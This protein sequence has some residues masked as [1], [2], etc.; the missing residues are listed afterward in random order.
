MSTQFNKLVG[1]PLILPARSV[2]LV[3]NA[4]AG[5]CSLLE[6]YIAGTAVEFGI[7]M[8]RSAL[9]VL[10]PYHADNQRNGGG[11]SVFNIRIGKLIRRLQMYLAAT[12]LNLPL[13][14]HL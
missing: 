6:R 9:V 3:C 10:L 4:D 11:P 7:I 14:L 5:S 13:S 1:F 12:T 8:V 2:A